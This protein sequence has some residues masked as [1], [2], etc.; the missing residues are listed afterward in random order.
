MSSVHTIRLAGPWELHTG[1]PS[2]QRVTLPCE[3]PPARD[4]THL[5]RKFHRPSGLEADGEVRIMLRADQP[6]LSV[7]LNGELLSPL[8]DT[9]QPDTQQADAASLTYDVTARLQSFNSL[10][11]RA[12][13]GPGAVLQAAVLEIHEP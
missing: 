12:A 1:S 3:L 11:V 2:P 7:Q 4:S 9:Q 10:T 8:P 13:E 6:S 5:L